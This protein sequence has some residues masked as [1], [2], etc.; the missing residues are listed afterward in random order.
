[1]SEH[2]LT[3]E[4]QA[5]KLKKAK[6]KIRTIRIWAWIILS[7]FAAT[8]A[9]SQCAMTKPQTVQNVIGSCVQNVP[10]SDKWQNDLSTRNLSDKS[11]AL[12]EPYCRCMWEEPLNKLTDKQIRSFSKLKPEEQLELLGGAAAFK[13]RDQ[14]CIAGLKAE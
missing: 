10:F 13:A 3:P 6:A 5:A 1:M 11:D 9:L 4:E 12:I 14:Q 7:L 2:E 8:L